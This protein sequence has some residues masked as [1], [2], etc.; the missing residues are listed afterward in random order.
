MALAS[1][2]AAGIFFTADCLS[3]EKREGTL[4]F[5]FLTDLRGYDVVAGKL[6]ATS[7]RGAYALLA[8]FPV[9]AVTLLMGGV[10]GAQF[11]KSSLALMNALFCSL[12][13]G[14]LVS[15]ASRN[16]QRAMAC[17]FLLLMLICVGGPAGDGLLALF[18]GNSRQ[19]LLSLGSPAY[20][21]W[22]SGAYG[23]T[24]FW[25]GLLTTHVFGW[26]CFALA[27]WMIVRTWQD[28][29][30]RSATDSTRNYALRYGRAAVRVVRRHKLMDP[31]PVMWLALRER[32]Q[33]AGLWVLVAVVLCPFVAITTSLPPLVWVVW[34]QASWVIV[35][36]LYLWTAAQA[37]RFFVDA[38]RTGLL[39]L[40]VVTPLKSE[41]IIM[42]QWCALLRTFGA[43]VLVLLIVQ[44][45]GTLLAQRASF[46][47]VA[48]SGGPPIVSLGLQFL[49][50][51]TS[52]IG[53]AANLAALMW[54]GM[55]TG[56]TSRNGSLAVLKT[57]VLVQVLPAL[58]ITFASTLIA[59]ALTL[60]SVFTSGKSPNA[61]AMSFPL[62]MTMLSALLTVGKDVAFIGWSRL[63]LSS[64]FRAEATRALNV[65]PAPPLAASVPPLPMPPVIT[66]Q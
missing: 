48:T 23:R 24:A 49:I 38:R 16:S 39:E 13:I 18:K 4:G 47:M 1:A 62:V 34:G 66:N 27:S 54:F 17:T 57:L 53:V 12:T 50:A 65:L 21:F 10:T 55:W 51:G 14:L 40:L 64:N 20:V 26:V 7:L 46:G 33:S 58:G 59:G 42:G 6:L 41:D 35:I 22:A 31:N 19:P 36:G 37:C 2:L 60:G 44:F 63:R 45:M 29:P 28:R 11:W 52:A 56:L 9:L 15:A 8:I 43:P 61:I 25:P 5:L 30:R 3:E 32:W